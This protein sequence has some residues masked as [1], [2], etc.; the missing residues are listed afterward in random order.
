MSTIVTRVG[1]GSTLTYAEADANFT[2]LNTD[3]YQ[4]TGVGTSS[5][6]DEF[7][8]VNPTTAGLALLD[9]ATASDQLTTLGGTTAGKAV[10]TAATVA[11]AQQAIGVE[12]GVDVQAYDVD[13]AKLDVDQAWTGAQRGT[14]TTDNDGS[15]DMAVTNNF[16]CT[17]SAGFTLTFTNITAGQSGNIY[18]VNG[19]NY[20]VAAHANT[21]VTSSLL[22][23]ISATGEYWL[24]YYSPDGSI[25][26]VT[27]AGDFA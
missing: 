12:V 8:A 19:S 15:F 10:F 5:N 4:I 2:N 11:A 25:V 18:L 20:A 13:T 17:P 9:D 24:S 7:A 6:L 23:L 3:K 21:K 14:V 26:L 1:K 22:S 16:L 27:A